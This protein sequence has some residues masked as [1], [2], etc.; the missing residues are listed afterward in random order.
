MKKFKS[1]FAVLSAITIL[2]ASSFNVLQ[3][4]ASDINT[5]GNELSNDALSED[6]NMKTVTIGDVD[7]S[8]DVDIVDLT[9]L[10]LYILGDA[11]LSDIQEISAD[12]DV[13]KTVDLSDLANL[14]QYISKAYDENSTILVGSKRVITPFVIN[15]EPEPE[16]FPDT[17]IIPGAECEQPVQPIVTTFVIN[18]E[19]EPEKFPDIT[20]IPGAECEQPIQPSYK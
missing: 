7:Q 17:T 19:P 11:Q 6:R 15:R 9:M 16:K 13:N 1:L 18:R 3:L 12:A 14:K 5:N 4:N 2:F 20:I 10:S 8:G